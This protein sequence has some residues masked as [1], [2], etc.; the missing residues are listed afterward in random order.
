[1]I[2]DKI[3][4]KASGE[5]RTGLAIQLKFKMR[6]KNDYYYS[7][8]LDETGCAEIKMDEL[9]SS[10]D[11]DRHLF[12]M[13]YKDP[14]T[15]F[16]GVIEP[17]VLT[18]EEIAAQLRGHEQDKKIPKYINQLVFPPRYWENLEKALTINVPCNCTITVDFIQ[19][20]N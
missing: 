6:K 14:R 9:L 11:Q 5:F 19:A 3:K 13:D 20:E 4:I 17:H 1:M 16:T 12:L 10:F 15:E 7:V 8:F 18:K 2:P